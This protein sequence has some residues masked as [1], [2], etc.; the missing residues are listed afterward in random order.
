M[1]CGWRIFDLG[2]EGVREE[3][4][5]QEMGISGVADCFMPLYLLGGESKAFSWN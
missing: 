2:V 4:G 5:V 3:R 1:A